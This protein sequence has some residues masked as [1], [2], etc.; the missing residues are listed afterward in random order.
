MAFDIR[1]ARAEG[2]NDDEIKDYFKSTGFD[3]DGAM[4]EGYSLDEIATAVDTTRVRPAPVEP[5]APE[6]VTE[7][8]TKPKAPEPEE[9]GVAE[10][11][12]KG[13]ARGV[14]GTARGLTG[15]LSALGFDPAKDM[16]KA[17]AGFEENYLKVEDPNMID[18]IASGF[19]SLA[20]FFIPGAG[21]F[22]VAKAATAI[23]KIAKAAALLGTSAQAVLESGVEAGGV[24]NSLIEKG[25]SED[26]ARSQAGKAFVA[27][28][29]LNYIT[30]KWI[31]KWMPEGKR[32]ADA[33]KGAGK[34]SVQEGLQ[35]AISNITTGEDVTQGIGTS[36]VVGAVTGGGLGAAKGAYE[37][38]KGNATPEAQPTPP[39]DPLNSIER[40]VPEAL[41]TTRGP[42]TIEQQPT[43]MT[44]D[45]VEG[46]EQKLLPS[47][48]APTD[49][50]L[51]TTVTEA[52]QTEQPAAPTA[53]P[54][55][56]EQ[57]TGQVLAEPEQAQA[58]KE[59]KP[60]PADLG[61]IGYLGRGETR[62]DL[63]AAAAEKTA[64]QISEV[65]HASV[66]MTN[67][68]VLNTLVGHEQA[69]SLMEKLAGI[70]KQASEAAAP[71][72]ARLTF[73][74]PGGDEFSVT[75]RNL[76]A[77]ELRT[78][79]QAGVD[80]VA[81]EI[82]NATLPGANGKPVALR[83]VFHPKHDY[84]PSG[85]GYF[86]VGVADM[87][88][89]STLHE[90]VEMAD[91]RAGR[92]G[93][94][95]LD[96]AVE[97]ARVDKGLNFIYNKSRKAYENETSAIGR[98]IEEKVKAGEWKNTDPYAD[99][100]NRARAE[101]EQRGE[102]ELR[103]QGSKQ[104]RQPG[105]SA[106]GPG[107][108][109]PKAPGAAKAA[110]EPQAGGATPP[111]PVVPPQPAAGAQEEGPGGPQSSFTKEQA[112]A[113]ARKEPGK[114]AGSINL[115][116]IE[117]PEDLQKTI[118]FSTETFAKEQ[119]KDARGK[120]VTF[121]EVDA[122][123]KQLAEESGGDAKKILETA[124]DKTEK[125]WLYV[126]GARDALNR[127]TVEFTE[128]AKK[129]AKTKSNEDLLEL[130][131]AMAGYAAVL[132]KVNGISA[133]VGRALSL[134]RRMSK[135]LDAESVLK[136]FGGRDVTADMAA[137]IVDAMNA[138]KMN[139]ASLRKMVQADT[140]DKVYRVWLDMLL[141]AP[142]THAANFLSNSVTVGLM[143]AERAAAAVGALAKGEGAMASRY[144]GEARQMMARAGY[145]FKQGAKA[146]LHALKTGGDID[147]KITAE[148][149]EDKI[150]KA[151]T[152]WGALRPTRWL[153]AADQMFKRTIYEMELG[154]QA[155]RMARKEGA[156]DVEGR[157]AELM[158]NPTDAMVARAE[159]EADYRTFT[160]PLGNIGNAVL[161]LRRLTPG[162]RWIIPFVKTPTNIAKFAVERTGH[163]LLRKGVRR[164]PEEFSEQVGKALV[165][166]GLAGMTLALVK[167]GMFTG[168]GPKDRD[169]RQ[170]LYA[171]GWL[172]YAA[173]IGDKYYS[174]AR[175]EP[176]ASIMGVTAD[177][178][179]ILERAD[180]MKGT[181][182]IGSAALSFTKNL[183]SK[184]FLTGLSNLLNAIEDPQRYG[185]TW[186]ERMAGTIVPNFVGSLAKVDDNYYREQD[187]LRDVVQAKI[188]G[189]S[190]ELRPKRDIWGRPVVRSE[191]PLLAFISPLA[192]SSDKDDA[193]AEEIVRVRA[194]IGGVG[195]KIGSIELNSEME[196]LYAER[197]GQL[198]RYRVE[199]LVKGARYRRATDEDKA[200]LIRGEF[201]E[202]RKR[203]RDIVERKYRKYFVQKRREAKNQEG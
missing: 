187:N 165:G 100:A 65:S 43:Q 74:R 68:T 15:A 127:A 76:T 50:P 131:R 137:K 178:A 125:Q 163:K 58:N 63:D 184:T 119:V 19:G 162:A 144:M 128:I 56:V 13:F 88:E 28:L 129:A 89:A 93:V 22:K 182:I 70:F 134:M 32:V 79:T 69:N 114:Y 6:T 92:A 198:A 52:P 159:A 192:I 59:K 38:V 180:E 9:T 95:R 82:D 172:P 30:D 21:V 156:K 193:V 12:G 33:L 157:V 80:A 36:M 10:R 46:Q 195:N 143:P 31:F 152:K 197:A 73:G 112:E 124:G 35:Q 201:A 49:I 174:I 117:G 29:P 113:A 196:D 39:E 183:A 77:E 67:L 61:K 148:A 169:K 99:L 48:E 186:V 171:T 130:R 170:A 18:N 133:D 40:V 118:D 164:N 200:E 120:R 111:P 149:T 64:G 189:L 107:I 11:V 140:K 161:K 72:Q 102:H 110:P 37:A 90:M 55:T 62:K 17:I 81:K 78:A 54:Q 1:G 27:N 51:E 84:L 173:K 86:N 60:P 83:E 94:D 167:A 3:V 91:E 97:R 108:E 34:E 122:A 145:G 135:P 14:T 71:A 185:K 153:Q 26:E 177:A 168:G 132:S 105:G 154:A 155:Y 47:N 166:W 87:S 136:Q 44:A 53:E 160:Q 98:I 104:I 126:N 142:T 121:E 138:G 96:A 5:V 20:T 2:Y 103:R 57:Q 146:A 41:S 23:P 179:E 101:I 109:G 116:R 175:L 115:T 75:G 24:Y 190:Q 188:P 66:D 123:V 203:A 194:N 106:Q 141:S 85:S 7:I 42:V 181:E 158:T 4:K 199:R 139:P 191:N 16:D 8:P 202:A 45:Q 151:G 25:L 176:F 150:Q 147:S